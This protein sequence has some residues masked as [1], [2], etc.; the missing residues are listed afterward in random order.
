MFSLSFE[1]YR[2]RFF[3]STWKSKGG[4]VLIRARALIREDT[5]FFPFI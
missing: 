5:V 2:A 4:G 3:Y 1:R